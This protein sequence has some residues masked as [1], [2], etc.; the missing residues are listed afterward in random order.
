MATTD[1]FDIGDLITWAFTFR[2][3][4][5]VLTDPSGGVVITVKDPSGN[6]STP[7]VTNSST[8]VYSVNVTLDEAGT[9]YARALSAGDLVGA[10]EDFITVRTSQVV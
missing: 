1:I 10:A 3:T 6:T 2:N 8:G 7:S 9:W 5:A 4:S